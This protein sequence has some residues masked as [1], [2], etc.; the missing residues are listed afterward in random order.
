M[1][2]TDRFYGGSATGA[3]RTIQDFGLC[4]LKG[5]Y[6][7]TARLRMKGLLTVTFFTPDSLPSMRALEALRRWTKEIPMDK[8][9]A[10]ALTDGDRESLSTFASQSSLDGVTLLLDYEWYQTRAWGVS[11]LPTTFLIDGKTGRV[12]CKVM[13][14]D[15]E[16]LGALQAMLGDKVAILVAA[17]EAARKAAEEKKAA[18]AAAAA[19]APPSAAPAKA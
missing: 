6:T 11:H 1:P 17:D 18:D 16:E 3:S 7:Y 8:W 5:A 9:A 15:A 13:G 19:A 14:D 10:I 4:D 2:T 12:L